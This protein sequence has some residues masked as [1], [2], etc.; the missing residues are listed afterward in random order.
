MDLSPLPFTKLTAA[1]ICG[2][3]LHFH[4]FMYCYMTTGK[5]EVKCVFLHKRDDHERQVIK[6]PRLQVTFSLVCRL[7]ILW[8][9]HRS[10]INRCMKRTV[11]FTFSGFEHCWN[12]CFWT[13]SC[14]ILTC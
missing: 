11:K 10:F 12:C 14:R 8:L 7:L 6:Q 2:G 1:A 3:E 5:M 4:V 13:F 9:Y